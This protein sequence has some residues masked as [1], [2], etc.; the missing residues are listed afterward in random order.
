MLKNWEHKPQEQEGNYLFK[1]RI[2]ITAGIR[3]ELKPHE[4]V[5]IIQKLMAFRDQKDMIDYLQVFVRKSDLLKVF[6]IDK[7]SKEMLEGDSYTNEQ[8]EEYNY[9]TMLLA[10]EY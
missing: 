6:C 9:W 8:K 4:I 2:Y 1:G 10:S 5:M 3:A 7:L